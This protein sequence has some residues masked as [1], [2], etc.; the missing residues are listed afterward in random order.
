[1]YTDSETGAQCRDNIKLV[2]DTIWGSTSNESR[3]EVGLK[4]ATFSANGDK[5]RSAFAREFIE[6]VGGH[7]YLTEEIRAVEISAVLEDLMTAHNGLNNFHTE[8]IPAELLFRLV[9][10][11]HIPMAVT[12]KYVKVVTMC[13]IGNGY[14]VSWAAEQ[15][16]SEMVAS[17]SEQETQELIN[18]LHDSDVVSRLQFTK[19][20]RGYKATAK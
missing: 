17:F 18:L 1:M 10:T 4:V 2:A 19:C 5:V 6:I 15:Y 9:Q 11:G 16:Y 3:G 14:G 13:R 8:R 20:V 7:G 12:K